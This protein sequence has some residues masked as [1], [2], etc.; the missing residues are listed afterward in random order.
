MK[1]ECKSNK[2]NKSE[3]KEFKHIDVLNDKDFKNAYENYVVIDPGK[4]VIY[5]ILKNRKR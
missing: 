3:N 2:N 4:R 1:N 5:K